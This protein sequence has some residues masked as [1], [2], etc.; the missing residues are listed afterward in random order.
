MLRRWQYAYF[1]CS[2]SVVYDPEFRPVL[3]LPGRDLD[4]C[5]APHG[6]CM[7]AWLRIFELPELAVSLPAVLLQGSQQ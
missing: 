2:D 7:F 1:R 4:W 6:M 5:T 3:H